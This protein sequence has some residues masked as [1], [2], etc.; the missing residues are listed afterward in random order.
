LFIASF[1]ERR[2]REPPVPDF[3]ERVRAPQD[4][5]ELEHVVAAAGEHGQYGA[6]GDAEC[7]RVCGPEPRSKCTSLRGATGS[8]DVSAK[9][10][11]L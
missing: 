11:F 10:I 6:S 4:N 3:R 5:A 9:R 2:Q 7:T 8:A 1:F